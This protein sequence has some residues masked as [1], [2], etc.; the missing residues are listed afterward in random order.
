MLLFYFPALTG[1]FLESSGVV[2]ADIHKIQHSDIA[3]DQIGTIVKTAGFGVP[4]AVQGLAGSLLAGP[5]ER[6]KVNMTR[7]AGEQN[8]ADMNCSTILAAL[9]QPAS[10]AGVTSLSRYRLRWPLFGVRAVATKNE[11]TRFDRRAVQGAYSRAQCTVTGA[12]AGLL[13]QLAPAA[14][15]GVS[16]DR[17]CGRQFQ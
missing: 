9:D 15:G 14:V 8:G 2:E 3:R 17:P 10:S 1:S 7:Q 4:L 12:K 16:L 6:G 11:C 13:Q 5:L